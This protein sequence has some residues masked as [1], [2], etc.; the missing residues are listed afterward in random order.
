MQKKQNPMHWK[1][2]ADTG[3][4]FT[5]CLALDPDG[6][7]HRAKVLSN[8]SLKAT[9]KEKISETQYT[10][11]AEWLRQPLFKGFSL[12][13]AGAPAA[14]VKIEALN[15][16]SGR[17]TIQEKPS[18]NL[19]VGDT[20]EI[21]AFEEAPVLAARLLTGTPLGQPFPPL[22]MRLG[23]TKG[24]NALL[25]GK[26]ARIALLVT[27]GFGDL[28]L[29]GDQRRPKLF[30]LN[31]QK[32]KPLGQHVLEVE[33]RLNAAGEVEQALSADEINRLIGEVKALKVEA[34]AIS[35]M[36][37]YKNQQ[38]EQQ[39]K[40]ALQDAGVTFISVSAELS[41][42]IK[43]LHRTETAVVNA[44]LSPVIFK[45]TEEVQQGLSGSGQPGPGH[46]G[47]GRSGADF[48]IMTSA[49]ALVSAAF[50]QPKDSLL[51]G[52]AGG[53]VGAAQAARQL[54]EEKVLT[55]DMG[56]TSTD[57]A[58]YD[59]AF[60]FHYELQVGEARLQ[61][62]AVA[63]ETVAAGGGSVCHTDGLKLMVGPE[64]AGAY[65]GPAC[66]GSGGPLTVTDV[67]LLLGHIY[68][69]RFH[70]P[71][72]QEK[73]RRAFEQLK[74]ELNSH[75]EVADEE[76][77][78]GLLQIANEKMAEAIRSI[79]VRRGYDP[80][81]YALMGFGGAGGQHVCAIAG[82]LGMQKVIVPYDAS[83]L[84][85]SGIHQAVI[86]RT[87]MRQVLKPLL[88]VG[89][90]DLL[91]KEVA[92]EA[93][94]ALLLEKILEEEMEVKE[95]KIFLRF[96]GQDSSIEVEYGRGNN[97]QEA[98]KE[99]YR[100]LYGHWLDD[101]EI[102][103]ESVQLTLASRSPEPF[104]PGEKMEA[105]RAETTQHHACWVGGGW[106]KVPVY[107]WDE[108]AAGATIA[109]PALLLSDFT[110]ILVEPKW[111]LQIYPDRSAVLEQQGTKEED[112]TSI[113]S[114]AVQL[115]LFTN[116]FTG[117]A[118]EMGSLL[119]RTAFSV[120]V[121]ERLD[122]SCALM[123]PNGYLVTN[124]PHIPVHLGSLG[125][126][127]RL[128]KEQYA[129]RPGDVLITNHPAFGGSHLPDITMISG[130]FDAAE[131]LLG[132]VA[133]RAHHAE[134]GGT[135]PG[136][137]PPDAK[138]LIEEG[139]V[140]PPTYLI[141]EG[142]PQWEVVERLLREAPYP[143]RAISENLADLKAALAANEAGRVALLSMAKQY[144]REEVLHYMQALCTY[145]HESL[146]KALKGFGYGNYSAT[147]L[148]DDGSPLK[149]AINIQPEGVEIDF[150]GSADVHPANLNVNPAI[151]N[152][153]IMYSLRLL[154]DKEIPLNEGL[155]EGVQVNIP[156][157]SMLNP[158]F[159]QPAEK[160]PAVVGGNTE[161]SQRLTDLML[162]AFGVSA[163]SHGSMNNLLFGNEHFGYYET[164]GGG[165]GA[166]PGF[167]GAD[168]VH[169]HMTNT[170]ITDPEILEFRYPVQLEAF[171]IRKGSG[172]K[173]KWAGGN[174]IYRQIRFKEAVQL[175]VLTQHRQVAP[176]GADGGGEGAV[177]R[178]YILRANGSC[179]EL[180]GIDGADMAAG[181]A[182]VMETPG[183]G[184]YGLPEKK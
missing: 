63:I 183:G 119:E 66:Y 148:L 128:V 49:G 99:K 170:R 178:Q 21:S 76:I 10:L 109:G 115:E 165:S 105:H 146:H 23:S 12:W 39:L 94:Q 177:G 20:V 98:F 55:L 156:A 175:S 102:E 131:N 126:C 36:H 106:Q 132:Y 129:I 133:N 139:V 97:L 180:Q 62:K 142:V 46:P 3:G 32:R 40:R 113:T 42:A 71:L 22:Q 90:L 2:A 182:V 87:A 18:F 135:R 136:S 171:K 138:S 73:A 65:P 125:V 130:V 147:E 7:T 117:I 16:Q 61:S 107:E 11:S 58:R 27:K 143:S 82:L 169:Q 111:E 74:Q 153:V 4:T 5:D 54:G 81:E 114:E 37:S 121:K 85:A 162:K 47:S 48:K 57:V 101:K 64:S 79:S 164:I 158:D 68:P 123:D 26:G 25:E 51:S 140:I 69:G 53:V 137:M 72:H 179:E 154:L 78:A 120:N 173:G 166:G 150:A 145:A 96:K 80:K 30:A 15:P 29:I 127:T 38:H 52:P 159:Q 151:V 6:N 172:G 181:D 122:F 110:S 33:E 70:I 163:C 19:K 161:I 157:G 152:S 84:S 100:H 112:N 176:Y 75:G 104:S 50:F 83:I 174:G 31:I 43:Y 116:R 41:P 17:L 155:M 89:N 167:K 91:M 103:L 77:M 45:Y 108:Q 13:K 95:Q 168:S 67:N 28:L 118:E 144:G 60:S 93:R 14:T 88:E 184:G 92:A 134:I 24:T 44:Y 59:Q 56:G 124:A 34:V 141:K 9:I 8:G 149:V 1:I 160:C 86:E 35:L